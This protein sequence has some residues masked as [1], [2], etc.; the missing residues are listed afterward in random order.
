MK[1]I[2]QA[3]IFTIKRVIKDLEEI[4]RYLLKQCEYPEINI[5]LQRVLDFKLEMELLCSKKE[6]ELWSKS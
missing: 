5:V 2:N 4:D 1:T 6:S 3:N